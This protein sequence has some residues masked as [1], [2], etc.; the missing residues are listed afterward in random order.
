MSLRRETTPENVG[1]AQLV[2][3][4]PGISKPLFMTLK[5]VACALTSGNP[6]P[7]LFQYDEGGNFTLEFDLYFATAFAW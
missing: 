4:T 3:A 1:L 7:V 6:L 5:P 2:P